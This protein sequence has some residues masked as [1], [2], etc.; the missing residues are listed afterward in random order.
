MAA[1]GHRKRFSPLSGVRTMKFLRVLSRIALL[2]VAAA[3]IVGLT[4][5]HY[6]GAAQPVLPE[7]TIRH[8]GPAIRALSGGDAPSA[9]RA[10]R[11][12]RYG[13]RWVGYFAGSLC[14]GGTHDISI[15]AKPCAAR[16]RATGLVGLASTTT[17]EPEAFAR[18]PDSSSSCPLTSIPYF[19][20]QP[21][22]DQ[23]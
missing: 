20:P 3:V 11:R 14:L 19:G 16:R 5:T 2:L 4:W 12:L 18:F 8:M 21:C 22:F 7:A 1:R 13:F 6:G 9:V 10:E 17:A 15:A 23:L